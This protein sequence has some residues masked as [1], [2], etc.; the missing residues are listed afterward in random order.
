M[1]ISVFGQLLL[2]VADA[3]A[4]QIASFQCVQCTLY[5]HSAAIR[6]YLKRW[7]TSMRNHNVLIHVRIYSSLGPTDLLL[8]PLMHAFPLNKWME[9]NRIESHRTHNE[10]EKLRVVSHLM[11]P[12]VM[13]DAWMDWIGLDWIQW[14]NLFF[15]SIS[16]SVQCTMHWLSFYTLFLLP[17]LFYTKLLSI[18][19]PLDVAT[20]F[21][22]TE[23]NSNITRR[24]ILPLWRNTNYMSRLTIKYKLINFISDSLLNH[25]TGLHR[26]THD[27]SEHNFREHY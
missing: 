21:C 18:F 25:K 7:L 22:T 14:A 15:T 20:P 2:F 1:G 17:L 19:V 10:S 12:Y 13:N 26:T 16:V 27:S 23:T 4:N 9:S 3:H 11:G 6:S 24:W 5:T 8:L